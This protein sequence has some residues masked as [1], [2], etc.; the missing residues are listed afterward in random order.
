MTRHEVASA[1]ATEG[2]MPVSRRRALATIHLVQP[3]AY[4]QCATYLILGPD[5][6]VLVDPGSGIAEA[7]VLRGIQEAGCR[8]EDIRLVLLTH[9]HSDHTLGA[10][11]F[12]NRNCPLVAS[13]CT[14]RI[15]GEGGRQVWY[16]FPEC[17]TPIKVDRVVSDGETIEA[18]GLRITAVHTP[19]HTLG[20]VSY[21]VE[22]AEGK[23]VLTGDLLQ[24]NGSPAWAGS[25]G[26]SAATT[27]ASVKKL[28][29]RKPVRAFWGHAIIPGCA[30]DWLRSS[31]AREKAGLWQI[32]TAF[33]PD[34]KPPEW[35]RRRC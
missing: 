15:L 23:A 33:H 20:C 24:S 21:F 29:R 6:A 10:P 25:E 9:C 30:M 32:E 27:L 31:V 13:P 22:T 28:F 11:R 17:V 7:N 5:G 4:F 12:Q 34:A 19:G 1:P 14:A 26:F 3:G 8:P 18:A 2:K 35:M 16:E